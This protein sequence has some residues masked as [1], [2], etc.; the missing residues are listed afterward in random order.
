V[1]INPHRYFVVMFYQVGKGAS[2]LRDAAGKPDRFRFRDTAEKIARN[3]KSREQ[4][5]FVPEM[6]EGFP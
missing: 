6:F 2:F 1:L 3:V 4:W 5:V